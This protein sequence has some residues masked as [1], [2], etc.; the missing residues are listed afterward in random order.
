M[1]KE[2]VNYDFRK[3]K[4]PASPMGQG[5]FANMPAAPIM[6]SFSRSHDYRDGILNNP[7]CGIEKE[8][9]IEE[10]YVKRSY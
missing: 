9:G 1:K 10:N 3:Q 8:S 7:A 2:N 5:D 6:R 4:E